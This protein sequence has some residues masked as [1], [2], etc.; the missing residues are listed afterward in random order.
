MGEVQN[1]FMKNMINEKGELGKKY[2][3]RGMKR[4]SE[5]IS[6]LRQSSFVIMEFHIVELIQMK[7]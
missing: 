6:Q 7:N 5:K 3:Y 1:A 4:S 2:K